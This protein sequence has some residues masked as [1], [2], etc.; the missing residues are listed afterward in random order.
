M[1]TTVLLVAMLVVGTIAWAQRPQERI[2]YDAA[3]R[4]RAERPVA[5]T[6]PT[7]PIRPAAPLSGPEIVAIALQA[8]PPE[9]SGETDESGLRRVS[10]RLRHKDRAA[11][12]AEWGRVVRSASVERVEIIDA[13]V[14]YVLNDAYLEP[15]AALRAEAEKVRFYHARRE[16]AYGR[17]G[18]L[19]RAKRELDRSAVSTQTV[20]IRSL[21]LSDE[22]AP[23]RSAATLG[24]EEPVTAES[25]AEELQKIV[26][27]CNHADAQ[28]DKADL[29]LQRAL[30]QRRETLSVMTAVSRSM[31]D[32]AKNMINNVR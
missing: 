11:A 20:T 8:G 14:R 26:V 32:T 4:V 24:P 31:H 22:Y 18:E 23:G 9:G 13:M 30:E 28:A 5:P 21:T 7:E 3:P 17:R 25:V 16:A 19:E 1:R 2:R 27:L 12:E 15:D 10:E 6:R 29:E